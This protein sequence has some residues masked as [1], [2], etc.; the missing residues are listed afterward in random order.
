MLTARLAVPAAAVV[1]LPD[2]ALPAAPAAGLLGDGA[3]VGK[4]GIWI[5]GVPW[6]LEPKTVS[7][8]NRRAAFGRLSAGSGSES[9][10]GSVNGSIGM[11]NCSTVPV[12]PLSGPCRLA[13]MRCALSSSNSA[14]SPLYWKLAVRSAITK[15]AGAS[16]PR[17]GRVWPF[18]AQV[19]ETVI[20]SPNFHG[21]RVA[22]VN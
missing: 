11:S 21:R 9:S 22:A 5:R 3:A 2:D 1:P 19:K 17:L 13:D 14:Q 4:S 10:S 20:G 18:S 12:P 6:S 16:L 15:F 7:S 8:M